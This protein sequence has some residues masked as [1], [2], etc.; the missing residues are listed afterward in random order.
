VIILDDQIQLL[1]AAVTVPFVIVITALILIAEMVAASG[2]NVGFLIASITIVI[3][4]ILGME[5]IPQQD[6][7]TA[8]I[9]GRRAV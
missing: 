5:R 1:V 9:A 6:A 8:L 7:T 2:T 4:R 3:I